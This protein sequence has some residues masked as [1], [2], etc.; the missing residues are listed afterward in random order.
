M[1]VSVKGFQYQVSQQCAAVIMANGV[2]FRVQWFK[3]QLF[4]PERTASRLLG[5]ECG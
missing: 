1:F 3:P 2:S 5:G 4:E